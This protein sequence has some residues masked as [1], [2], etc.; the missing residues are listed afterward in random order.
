[1]LNIYI[2][3]YIFDLLLLSR[4]TAAFI[5]QTEHF[6]TQCRINQGHQKCYN[7]LN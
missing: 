5:I 2:I 3:N 6:F 1:M 4:L 7:L